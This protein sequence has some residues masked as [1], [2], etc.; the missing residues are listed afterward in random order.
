MRVVRTWVE[1]VA[2]EQA[3]NADFLMSRRTVEL[4]VNWT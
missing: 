4:V 2:A 3:K 1:G